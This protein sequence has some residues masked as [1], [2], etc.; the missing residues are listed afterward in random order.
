MHIETRRDLFLAYDSIYGLTAGAYV[1]LFPAALAKQ[2]EIQEFASINGLLY[3]I[4]GFGT[5]TGTSVGAALVGNSKALSV[6][7]FERAFLFAGV[8]V[9]P[10]RAF[11]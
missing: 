3:M 4:R 9:F 6:S 5:L 10:A 2:F 8:F 11:Q 1:S 7:S